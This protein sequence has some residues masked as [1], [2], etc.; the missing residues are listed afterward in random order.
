M[1]NITAL[2]NELRQLLA[3]ATT[4]G[5]YYAP[6]YRATLDHLPAL[7]DRLEELEGANVM[8]GNTVTS[9]SD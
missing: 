3:K 2:A 5:C 1:P 7:L 8:L 4:I 9:E 6:L